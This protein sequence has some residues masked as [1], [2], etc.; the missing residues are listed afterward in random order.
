MRSYII[1]RVL[2][3]IPTLFILTVLVFLS[4][5]F[6]P[7][8]IIDVMAS[9]L[10]HSLAGFDR[11]TLE[12]RL[13]LDVP[14]Y[15]QYGRWIGVLPTPDWVTVESHFKG[16]L[17]GNLGH[18]LV[19][20]GYAIGERIL[21]AGNHR[22]GCHV[23]RNRA[24]D[25]PTGRHLLG[26]SPGYGGRLR[27]ALHRRSGPGNAQLLAGRD[28]DDLPGHL[29]GL[30]ATDGIC[31][32]H[33]RPAGESWHVPHSQPDCGDGHVCGHHA[34]DTHHD[35]GGASA[36]LHPD[37]LVQGAQVAGGCRE[38]RRQ[39]CPHPGGV[40]DRPAIANPG[41]RRRHHGEHLQPAG[42]G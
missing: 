21:V 7:G 31:P 10:D 40:L 20:G 2:L 34:D 9:R 28:G 17:Q 12:R 29:V 39:E 6:I 26:N 19:G 23:H 13:G 35:A 24:V 11:E 8:D 36:G 37:G 16:L 42:V 41:G 18:S 22:A 1:R 5:R 4:V 14:M 38:T 30:G 15:V 3:I 32:F 25:S 33:R 27:R